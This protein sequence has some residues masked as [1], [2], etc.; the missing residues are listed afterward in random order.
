MTKIQNTVKYEPLV[1]KITVSRKTDKS[2]NPYF[3]NVGDTTSFFDGFYFVPLYDKSRGDESIVKFT[4]E[5]S[6]SYHTINTVVQYEWDFGDGNKIISLDRIK[7]KNHFKSNSFPTIYYKFTKKGPNVNNEFVA[8][9]QKVTFTV[10]DN[11]G[12]KVVTSTV[13]YPRPGA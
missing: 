6:G 10:I 3:I 13:V 12:R 5:F 1:P 7:N 9:D 4:A 11:A 2:L 8:I